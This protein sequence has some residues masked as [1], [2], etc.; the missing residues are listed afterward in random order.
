MRPQGPDIYSAYQPAYDASVKKHDFIIIKMS[1]GGY[2]NP[3]LRLG[4]EAHQD[5]PAPQ[6]TQVRPV[7]KV[8]GYHYLRYDAGVKNQ[9]D[10]ILQAASASAADTGEG[11]ERAPGYIVDGLAVDFEKRNNRPSMRFGFDTKAIIDALRDETGLR[12]FFYSNRYIIQDWLFQYGNYWLRTAPDKYPLW[13]A[14]YP[15]FGWHDALNDVYQDRYDLRFSSPVLP[16]GVSDWQIWQYSADGNAKGPENGLKQLSYQ[17]GPPSI[18]LN[19][20][21][22]SSAEA[23]NAYLEFRDPIEEPAPGGG[24]SLDRFEEGKKAGKILGY[25]QALTEVGYWADTNRKEV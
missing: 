1:E 21:N 24:G 20:G 7:P 2:I 22:F 6:L 16:A 8:I 14:Q 25:N 15:Y 17:T 5:Q 10:T 18:D 12:V 3:G 23:F 11:W 19:V 9:V 4:K 13:I